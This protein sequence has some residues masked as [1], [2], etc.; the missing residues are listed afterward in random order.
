MAKGI[1]TKATAVNPRKFLDKVEPEKKR[2]DCRAILKMMEEISGEP[3]TMWGPTI[4]GFGQY[5]Y[6]YESGHSGDMCRIGFAPRSGNIV[7]YL[8][9]DDDDAK[10]LGKVKKTKGCLYIKKLDDIDLAY[11]KKLIKKSYNFSH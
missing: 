4:V 7:L 2:D 8:S 5:H 11:L 10:K 6:E 1:K 9:A 3:A